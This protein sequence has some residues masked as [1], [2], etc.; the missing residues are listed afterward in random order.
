[1]ALAKR[2][3]AAPAEKSQIA[4][5]KGGARSALSH[6]Q[7][8]RVAT[9]NWKS[10]TQFTHPAEVVCEVHFR[11][12]KPPAFLRSQ[13]ARRY[14]QES[15]S[16]EN[17][18]DLAREVAEHHAQHHALRRAQRHA[19]SFATVRATSRTASCAASSHSIAR[20]RS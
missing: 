16:R 9:L 3:R 18:K 19:T 2:I 20:P 17:M 1:M 15:F 7:L 5:C 14:G 11:S 4:T 12:K 10:S 8:G 6:L 13:A